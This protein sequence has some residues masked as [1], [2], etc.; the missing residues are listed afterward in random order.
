[1]ATGSG[2]Y[3]SP[4][5]QSRSANRARHDFPQLIG[6]HATSSGTTAT[7][8]ERRARS[9][10]GS[11]ELRSESFGP[12][13]GSSLGGPGAARRR[14]AP[15]CTGTESAPRRSFVSHPCT[16]CQWTAVGG[17]EDL[18]KPPPLL[19]WPAHHAGGLCSVS[20]S[21]NPTPRSAQGIPCAANWPA[22][23][24]ARAASNSL[25]RS[26][27]SV[28]ENMARCSDSFTSMVMFAPIMAN[29]RFPKPTSLARDWPPPLPPT[30]WV[31]DRRGDPLFVVT[32]DANAALTRMLPIV[33]REVRQ[34]LGP[35]RRATVVFDRGG[36]SPKLFRELMA[37]GFDILTYRKGRTRR[38]A[39]A[40]FTQHKAKLDGRR[41]HYLLHEQ[42]VR[43]LKGKLRLRQITRLTQGGHQTPIVTSRW[44]LRAIVLAY[45]MF[46][47]WRQENFFKYVREEY[48]IDALADYEIEPDDA[49]RSVP[50]PA[51]KAI[52]KELR[53]MRAQ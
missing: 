12:L 29:T 40:R 30:Y 52:E 17:G 41:V 47:R 10:T 15:V 14:V 5:V 34:L 32:A 21:T 2:S 28:S 7:S 37:L 24:L 50:N 18:R 26:L 49:N 9:P 3:F 46:E 51:R 43:F 38:I 13:H 16:G 53:R 44:D 48:L 42:P 1:M 19:L 20:P 11:S 6:S 23:R 31:N 36:W 45:R 25:R 39:E 4:I 35:K 22:S 33:L 27:G 8:S